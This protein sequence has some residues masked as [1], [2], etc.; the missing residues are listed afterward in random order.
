MQPFNTFLTEAA[1]REDKLLH[2]EH[3]EDHV[4]HGGVEGFNHAI[5]NLNAV[6]GKLKGE[7]TGVDIQ[8][9]HDGSPSVLFGHH[10]ETGKFFVTSKSGFNKTP[11][12]NYTE[13]DIEENH[14][15][16]PGLVNKLKAALKH[17][18]KIAPK[19]GVFQGDIMYHRGG[20]GDDDVSQAYGKHHFK[21][22]TIT[23]STPVDSEE[24]KKVTRSK[25][26]ILVHTGYEGNTFA[27]MKAQYTP[28][29]SAFKQHKD[30][31]QFD[32]SLP[33]EGVKYTPEQQKQYE[34]HINAAENAYRNAPAD[35]FEHTL[36]HE[37]NLKTYINKTVKDGSTPNVNDYKAHLAEKSNKDIGKLKTDKAIGA[38]KSQLADMHNHI[39]NHTSHFEDMLNIHGHLTSAKHVL[40]D[41]MN[42]GQHRFEHSIGG[43]HTNPEGYV[44]VRNNR[45]SKLID[46]PEFARKNFEMSANR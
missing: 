1:S 32:N 24:G 14:G 30:V 26:G 28:D 41:A 29:K 37:E 46:R 2:L 8:V 27:D 39:D 36:P 7:D 33:T 23:Y 9:K 35:T 21:P 16:A 6:H 34:S 22:N 45:P 15:H 19:T 3:N 43:E 13:Q 38:R 42:K 20:E 5:N 4:I 31:H 40:L 11:K 10:P 44:V 12:I 17:L 18:P 25:F